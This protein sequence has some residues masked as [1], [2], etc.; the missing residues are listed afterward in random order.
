MTTRFIWIPPTGTGP[1]AAGLWN[2]FSPDAR[3]FTIC[4]PGRERQV[5]V[6]S[7]L[8]CAIIILLCVTLTLFSVVQLGKALTQQNI[9]QHC[10]LG[11][12]P[13]VGYQLLKKM[14]FTQFQNIIKDSLYTTSFIVII[15]TWHAPNDMQNKCY[16]QIRRKC[17][18]TDPPGLPLH[19]LAVCL[20]DHNPWPLGPQCTCPCAPGKLKVGI[21]IRVI[22]MKSSY[23]WIS[24]V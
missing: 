7:T 12:P 1:T 19:Q 2:S 14:R 16:G 17:S 20:E 23:R 24:Q 15:K 22:V 10:L 6:N 11:P 8:W 18:Q 9:M 5:D 4:S 13:Q 21:I 3:A